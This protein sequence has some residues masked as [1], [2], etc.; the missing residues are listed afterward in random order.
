LPEHL[1]N[2]WDDV[3]VYSALLVTAGM[4]VLAMFGFF[5]VSRGSIVKRIALAVC[6]LLA[7]AGIV[8]GV[9]VGSPPS[10]WQKVLCLTLTIVSHIVFLSATQAHRDKPAAAYAENARL[11]LVTS[12][13]YA[14]VRHPFYLAYLLV[15][16]AGAI[17]TDQWSAWI[18]PAVLT[19]IYHGTA[20][21]EEKLILASDHQES[22]QRYQK[23]TG[24][25]LP[26]VFRILNS[27]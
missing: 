2:G 5:L 19:V 26:K 8:Q 11:P 10:L 3:L 15:F 1:Q 6:L 12:G 16:L 14:Y 22:Y 25:L 4:F 17:V 13:P 27:R 24:M 9:L 7:A 21:A 20:H 23:N 18:G